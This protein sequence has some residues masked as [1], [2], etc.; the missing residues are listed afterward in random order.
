MNCSMVAGFAE[1]YKL[2]PLLAPAFADGNHNMAHPTFAGRAELFG[3]ASNRMLI[4]RYI[5]VLL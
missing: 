2:S 4:C 5:V 1:S 3:P